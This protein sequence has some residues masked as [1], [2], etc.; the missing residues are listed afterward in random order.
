MAGKKGAV[1]N[2]N[3][4]VDFEIHFIEGVL[5]NSPDFVQAL[6]ALGDLYTRKCF[7]DKGLEI[8]RKLA[9][10]KP[11]DP[12]VFYNLSCSY[13]LL[14][15]LEKSFE[16]LR[17]AVKYG[18]K[19]FTYMEGDSDLINLRQDN[20]FQQFLAEVKQGKKVASGQ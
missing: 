3:G 7:Y 18:Y 8:D 15:E 19:D 12:L 20:R 10:L 6:T 1:Q 14:H 5:K 16:A 17:R 4:D 13:S 11:F 9:E 2:R